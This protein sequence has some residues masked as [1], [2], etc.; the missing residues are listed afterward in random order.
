MVTDACCRA[1]VPMHTHTQATVCIS[2]VSHVALV[3]CHRT[4][5]RSC[6][7]HTLHC[8]L[9]QEV[10]RL[11]QLGRLRC[12][13]L[14]PLQYPQ[15]PRVCKPAPKATL[16]A[17]PRLLR[18]RTRAAEDHRSGISGAYTSSAYTSSADTSS[19]PG[20]A[21]LQPAVNVAARAAPCLRMRWTG[22]TWHACNRPSSAAVRGHRET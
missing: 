3:H 12:C 2:G 14:R 6:A 1:L 4:V 21:R 19:K 18:R 16:M 22:G 7:G 8:K 10:F 15:L 11:W 9:Q 5:A 17:L 20:T 13:Q